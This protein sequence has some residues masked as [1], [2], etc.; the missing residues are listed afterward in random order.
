MNATQI[1]QAILNG[2]LTNDELNTIADS[3]RFAR[4]QLGKKVKRQLTVG[5]AVSF[6][7]QG[8]TYTGVVAKV[9]IK[10]AQVRVESFRGI[11]NGHVRVPVNMLQV[12]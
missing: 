9:A 1:Q 2:N 3:L 7:D 12:I 6:N 5:S 4:T 10:F 11:H 8:R